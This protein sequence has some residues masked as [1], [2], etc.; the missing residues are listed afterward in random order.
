MSDLDPSHPVV[1]IVRTC[2]SNNSQRHAFAPNTLLVQLGLDSLELINLFVEL[3]AQLSM[4]IDRLAQLLGGNS[5]PTLG[6][7]IEMYDSARRTLAS[8]S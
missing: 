4:R 2:L 1:G 7:L 8:N 6:A 5:A 3:E